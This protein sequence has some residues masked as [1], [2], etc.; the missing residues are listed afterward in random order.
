VK[1][2][3]WEPPW[4]YASRIMKIAR[5]RAL[6]Y[7]SAFRIPSG[8]CCRCPAPRGLA[9]RC[10]W[11]MSSRDAI[12]GPPMAAVTASCVA[13]STVRGKDPGGCYAPHATP[14]R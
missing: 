3:P 8:H 7:R 5:A 4:R 1:R 9:C 12:H 11:S 14:C 10:S 13:V 6:R 2:Q